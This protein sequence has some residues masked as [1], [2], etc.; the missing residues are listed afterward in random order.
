MKVYSKSFSIFLASAVLTGC[1]SI[2]NLQKLSSV[3]EDA[4]SLTSRLM[5]EKWT[6]PA[7]IDLPTRHWVDSFSDPILKS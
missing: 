7:P 4:S 2:N 1:A 3:P 6:V 5:P